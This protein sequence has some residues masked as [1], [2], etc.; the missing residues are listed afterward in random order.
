MR[1]KPE[2]VR[3]LQ[4]E[5]RLKTTSTSNGK[6]KSYNAASVNLT[7]IQSSVL[8]QESATQKNNDIKDIEERYKIIFEN[9]AVAIT[10]ADQN[11]RIISWN[12]YTEELFN[13]SEKELFMCPVKSLY[14]VEEW[15]R[16][17][18]E[19]VR[20]RGIKYRMETRMLKKNGEI[21]DVELSLCILRSG[22]GKNAGSIGIIKDISK[23]KKT[24]RLLKDSE[25]R[26]RTIF[27]N[28]AVGIML[29]DENE[30][31]ISWNKEA[32]RLLDMGSSDLYLKPVSSL[33]PEDEWLRIRSENIREK[34]THLHIESKM[35]KK[36]QDIIDVAVSLSVLKNY[37]GKVIGSIGV[38]KDITAQKQMQRL[39]EESERKFKQ[40]YEY[41]PVPYH[42]LSPDGIITNVN[43]KWC[44]ILGYS[45][46]E[47]IGR[48]IFEFID[49]AEQDDAR[50]SFK[51]KI[52]NKD[53]YTG[54]HE[55]TL[56]TRT[57]NKHVFIINDFLSFNDDGCVVS[58][59]TTME[60][61]TERKQHEE[62]I[63]QSEEKYRAIFDL[64]PQT[65]LLF[66][67]VGFL[68]A[69]NPRLKDW[70]GYKPEEVIGR[71]LMDLPFLS[72][73]SKNT[74]DKDF[75]LWNEGKVTPAFELEFLSKIG[76]KKTGLLSEN[77]IR[78]SKANII[79]HLIMIS[80]VTERRRE[81]DSIVKS[82]EKYRVLAETSA[83]GVFTL[84]SLG[85]LTYINPSFEQIIGRRKSEMLATLFR[86]YLSESS[87]YLFQQLFIDV[88][89]SQRPVRNVELDLIH[90][91]GYEVPV[92]A[93]IAPLI[94]DGCFTGLECTI[95]D[96]T[97][98]KKVELELRKSDQ[99]KTEFMNIAAHELKSPVT[100]I[101][102]YLELIIDDADT[103]EKIRNW[104]KICYRNADRLLNLVNDILDVSRL[105]TDTMRFTMER[106]DTK[107][108][109]EHAS[110]DMR[111]AVEKKNL[112][113][114][115]EIPPDLPFI[116]GDFNRLSQVL[117]NLLTNSIKF[118][119]NG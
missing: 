80:D 15:E 64:S 110:Q 105:E 45:K 94:I 102:G 36:N 32:E 57:G 55:R 52:Q 42:T 100:P 24:E 59:H 51:N 46:D 53:R 78:D 5:E 1:G 39:L 79:G 117:K 82:E 63:R 22:E 99:L 2:I 21:F 75:S 69:A 85:R 61:I 37:E 60:D 26:Y 33:Y 13:M 10:L 67:K 106:I 95:R 101:K 92:E 70:L 30:R 49:P 84:D 86:N 48:S 27:E 97:E 9:Y 66:D 40:L 34:G 41:A 44:Q 73:D 71:R 113:F 118:T 89:Q 87:V 31:I 116:L 19:N 112:R 35:Y 114:I 104:A 119:D 56:I 11:E 83:D 7:N 111:L 93:N 81:W 65:I 4:E 96:I 108:L 8:L 115:T 109:L 58:V 28:S 3:I 20:Q 90:N 38:I 47:V 107:K 76:E 74:L 16:I 103:S 17:R 88:R 29:T 77:T 62:T 23:L 54:G 25:E 6:E 18:R 43:D 98:R 50:S 68:V 72:V 14:P 12:S 91:D